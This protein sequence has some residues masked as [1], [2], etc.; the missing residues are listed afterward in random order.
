MNIKMDD[1]LVRVEIER[2]RSLP[3]LP[4]PPVLKVPVSDLCS[5]STHVAVLDNL[6]KIK[7]FIE[8]FEYNYSGKPFIRMNK[9]KGS[10]HIFSVSK[11]LIK[12]GLPIQC[13]EA[14]FL[15]THLTAHMLE[16]ERVPLSFKTKFFHGTVH[17]HIVLAV[18]YEGKWGAIGISRRPNLMHKDVRFASLADLV[19]E[20]RQSYAECYH[21][22][23]TV[24]VGLPL[25][26]NQ[27]LDQPVK[28]R[29]TKVRMVS[30]S[31]EDVATKINS[32]TSVMAKMNE[33]YIREGCLP[34]S[35]LRKSFTDTGI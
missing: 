22:L 33:Y 19:E 20:F 17:R 34:E 28:W 32:F 14:V 6:K 4:D 35:S 10:S 12:E 16:M 31:A 1:P 9:S 3:V 27:C 26:H 23:L 2:I 18:R 25:P 13:V 29:A 15:G 21:K 7:D 5:T 30:N 24:Y 8:S 11:Q